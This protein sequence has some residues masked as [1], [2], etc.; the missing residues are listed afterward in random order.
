MSEI[1]KLNNDVLGYMI[2]FLSTEILTNFL[3]CCRKFYGISRDVKLWKIKMNLDFP[4]FQSKMVPSLASY[5]WL[6]FVS[7]RSENFN[8]EVSKHSDELKR[9]D[10][11]EIPKDIRMCILQYL[12]D[13][14]PKVLITSK[15]ER[16]AIEKSD[17]KIDAQSFIWW[18]C[19]VGDAF[20]TERILTRQQLGEYFKK[21]VPWQLESETI[22]MIIFQLMKRDRKILKNMEIFI[23]KMNDLVCKI[24]KEYEFYIELAILV[25]NLDYLGSREIIENDEDVRPISTKIRKLKDKFSSELEQNLTK[26]Q[27]RKISEVLSDVD[28]LGE[29]LD[30]YRVRMFAITHI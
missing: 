11:S 10:Q 30:K 8:A 1:E 27:V 20:V 14:G 19:C 3:G 9:F 26:K 12:L 2:D 15:F 5:G 24:P 18:E 25:A 23:K 6:K 16:N 7:R 22:E 21:G 17:L 13:N 29:H 4:L 28:I